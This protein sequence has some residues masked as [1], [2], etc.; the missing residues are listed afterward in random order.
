MITKV[1]AFIGEC[2][3]CKCL[4]EDND[5]SIFA[6][7]EVMKECMKEGFWYMGVGDPDHKDKHYCPDCFRFDEDVDDKIILD[8]S[9][10]DMHKK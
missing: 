8:E 10:K 7:K 3:N 5:Y 6:D 9:R 1:D 2:D 4:F